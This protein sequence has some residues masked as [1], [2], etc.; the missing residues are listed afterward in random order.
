MIFAVLLC[1][2]SA[3]VVADANQTYTY[4]QSN[5]QTFTPSGTV[6]TFTITPQQTSTSWAANWATSVTWYVGTVETAA[7]FKVTK[8]SAAVTLPSG[9]KWIQDSS[10]T[11]PI[12]YELYPADFLFGVNVEVSIKL[13]AQ[14]VASLDH[15]KINLYYLPTTQGIGPAIVLLA[16]ESWYNSS[17]MM[18]YGNMQRTGVYF[19]AYGN[20]PETQNQLALSAMPKKS[21]MPDAGGWTLIV[22]G[23]VA[24][25]A[26]GYVL[27][28]RRTR[29][30]GGGVA[31][32]SKTREADVEDNPVSAKAAAAAGSGGAAAA[33]PSHKK[34][35]RKSIK[36]QA[37]PKGWVE[38]DTDD[39]SAVY[40]YNESTGE[41]TWEK[42]NK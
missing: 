26:I 31:A 35:A 37:L 6:I 2:S 36:V 25:A 11:P 1:I 34:D 8:S 41:T 21:T 4:S 39:G 22:M 33:K 28:V 40:Y 16:S 5:S 14:S 3:F 12:M 18:V 9:L 23:L 42:P 17:S 30:A 19:A 7:Q 10:S 32:P 13:T 15:S 29:G 20:P 38:Y 24:V 27:Y